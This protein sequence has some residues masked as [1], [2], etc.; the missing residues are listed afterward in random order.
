LLRD[1]VT[2]AWML[3]NLQR[4]KNARLRRFSLR[5]CLAESFFVP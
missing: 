2:A 4:L 3:L 5:A 1:F